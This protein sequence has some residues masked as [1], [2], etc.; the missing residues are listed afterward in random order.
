MLPSKLT[1]LSFIFW[2][3]NFQ[4]RVKGE[5]ISSTLFKR[6][7]KW[8]MIWVNSFLLFLL[9]SSPLPLPTFQRKKSWQ[10]IPNSQLTDFLIGHHETQIINSNFDSFSNPKKQ[11]GFKV[12]L[13]RFLVFRFSFAASEIFLPSSFSLPLLSSPLLSF[14]SYP[15]RSRFSY[16]WFHLAFACHQFYVFTRCFPKSFGPLFWWSDFRFHPKRRN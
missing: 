13:I 3:E 9:P 12:R 8:L 4:I 5:I 11:F 7:S 1:N 10:T 16:R 6:V 2:E 14:L 15:L